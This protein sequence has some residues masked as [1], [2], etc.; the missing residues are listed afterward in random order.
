MPAHS[1]YGARFLD[2][3]MTLDV[4]PSNDID[5]DNLLICTPSYVLPYAQDLTFVAYFTY[6]RPGSP[7]F[8]TNDWGVIV[9]IS[10]AAGSTENQDEVDVY[11]PFEASSAQWKESHTV[12][13]GMAVQTDGMLSDRKTVQ[14]VGSVVDVIKAF[15]MEAWRYSGTIT[16]GYVAARAR[17]IKL[18]PQPTA[19]QPATLKIEAWLNESVWTS[20]QN[21]SMPY[22][23]RGSSTLPWPEY[24]KY[25]RAKRFE[26]VPVYTGERITDRNTDMLG[27]KR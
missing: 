13:A 1:G 22:H 25:D 23:D 4:F 12:V 11:Y 24:W 15:E 5:P 27:A 10:G 8:D 20:H 17:L 6:D 3:T 7:V 14:T 21:G 18:T 19:N 2:F 16:G 26:I 9:E